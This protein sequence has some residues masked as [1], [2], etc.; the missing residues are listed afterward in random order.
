[1]LVALLIMLVAL[2]IMLSF[3]NALRKRFK[4][5]YKTKILVISIS[6]KR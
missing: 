1:M 5:K 4:K 2:L 6:N 3:I